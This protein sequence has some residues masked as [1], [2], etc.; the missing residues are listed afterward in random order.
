[1][2]QQLSGQTSTLCVVYHCRR[3]HYKICQFE[4]TRYFEYVCVDNIRYITT[5][6]DL[7]QTLTEWF[8]V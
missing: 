2:N 1:M 8:C 6:C 3:Q 5:K 4:T 7:F